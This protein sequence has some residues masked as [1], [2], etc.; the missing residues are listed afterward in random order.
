MLNIILLTA[1]KA[2]DMTAQYIIDEFQDGD[3]GN[4]EELRWYRKGMLL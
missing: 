1:A 3:E 2:G 4:K